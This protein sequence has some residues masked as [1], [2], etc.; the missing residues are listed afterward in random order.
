[1]MK[2]K[3]LLSIAAATVAMAP[4]AAWA[5]DDLLSMDGDTLRGEVQRRYD[6]GLA[7]TQDAAIVS[8]NDPRY[9]WAS[10]TKVQCGI[11]LGFFKSG[12]RDETSISK[13]GMAYDMM[14][15]PPTVRAAAAP[16]PPPPPARV[17]EREGPSLIFFDFD[18]ATPGSD[19]TE[20]IDF[21]TQNAEACGWSSFQVVGH[22][23]R[24]GSNAYNMGLSRR[25]ADAVADLMA[26]Q[27]IVRTAIT[28]DAQGEESPRVPTADGVREL[29]NRR[30]EITVSQ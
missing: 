17:C 14:M 19:A 9:I 29:Q 13:C 8:A 1:M 12:T 16:P 2:K 5:Q 18:S 28:T 4:T 30:V 10:E 22:A 20:T 24:S 15:R 3:A 6:A 26:A 21:M 27:G 25:R 23:D 11:A 7:M